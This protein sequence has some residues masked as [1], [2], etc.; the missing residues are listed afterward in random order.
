ME[1]ECDYG[2]SEPIVNPDGPSSV[3]SALGPCILAISRFNG[4]EFAV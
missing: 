3:A 2:Y 4:F 1:R